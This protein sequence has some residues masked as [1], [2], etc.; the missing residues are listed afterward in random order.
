MILVMTSKNNNETYPGKPKHPI[1][2]YYLPYEEKWT[3]NK[4]ID[5]ALRNDASCNGRK[6]VGR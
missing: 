6:I 3:K 2:G 4:C 5:I 1:L